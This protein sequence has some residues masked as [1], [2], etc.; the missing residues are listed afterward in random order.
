MKMRKQEQDAVRRKI[1]GCT[2][3]TVHHVQCTVYSSKNMLVR[4][5]SGGFA[6]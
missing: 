2:L 6:R 3:Y 5:R 4:V 1:V